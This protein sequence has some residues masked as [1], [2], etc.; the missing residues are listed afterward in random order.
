M[1]CN[2]EDK[3]RDYYDLFPTTRHY[4]SPTRIRD[5]SLEPHHPKFHNGFCHLSM[6]T[7][8]NERY[9]E[10]VVIRVIGWTVFIWTLH[11]AQMKHVLSAICVIN[12]SL[13]TVTPLLPLYSSYVITNIAAPHPV[14]TSRFH[15]FM[16]RQ[17]NTPMVCI[18]FYWEQ[19]CIFTKCLLQLS[20]VNC[21]QQVT[22]HSPVL[23]TTQIKT[24]QFHNTVNL[25]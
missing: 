18:S 5:M 23:K 3:G 25:I 7:T 13:R 6:V 22:E 10:Y 15:Y 20:T 1:Y 2:N 14:E 8:L 16:G 12:I 4:N 24:G 19:W 11:L 17:S 21:K 9:I